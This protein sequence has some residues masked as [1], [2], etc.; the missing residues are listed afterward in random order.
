MNR[1][2]LI[3]VVGNCQARPLAQ[4]LAS[5]VDGGADIATVAIV[6]LLK[7]DNEHTYA[8]AFAAADFILAQSVADTYPCRFVQTHTLRSRYGAKVLT[9]PNLYFGGYN[10]ELMY[11]RSPDRQPIRG[12]LGDYHS[13]NFLAG[14]QR[15]LDV[16][17][18]LALHADEDYN[19][20]HYEGAPERAMQEL[21]RREAATDVHVCAWI[22]E[23]LWRTRLFFTFNH[24]AFALVH[25]TARQLCERS[26]LA[27]TQT[28]VV[29][30]DAK[31]P[32]GQFRTPMNPWIRRVQASTLIE[33]EDYAGVELLALEP[34]RVVVGKH[35][36]YAPVE[37]IEAFFRVYEACGNELPT[38]PSAMVPHHRETK[39]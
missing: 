35:R 12:P 24:P 31:E 22:R 34:G 36:R 2:P 18:T 20:R 37:V 33:A 16:A 32:L 8:S 9:W 3:A 23:R 10:P 29:V 13:A 14:W 25:E 7:D 39:P 26:G 11:L 28:P 1:R 30:A 17:A 4:A 6:H 27:C 19:R 21:E 15:G 5:V 38:I